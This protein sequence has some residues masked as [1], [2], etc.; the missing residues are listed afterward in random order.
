MTGVRYKDDPAIFAWDLMNEPQCREGMAGPNPNTGMVCAAALQASLPGV[1]LSM[2]CRQSIAVILL[3]A[4][5]SWIRDMAAFTKSEDPNHLLTVG[6]EGY[7]RLVSLLTSPRDLLHRV[8]RGMCRQPMCAMC[9]GWTH[10]GAFQDFTD[11]RACP[12]LAAMD[13]TPSS[14]PSTRARPLTRDPGMSRQASPESSTVLCTD[15]MSPHGAV[16]SHPA[17]LCRAPVWLVA[18]HAAP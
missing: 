12:Q 2:E 14:L 8:W 13:R 18:Y 15:C 7:Y 9:A 11:Q 5:Q 17:W 10:P 1:A 16:S 3:R 4:M 6:E